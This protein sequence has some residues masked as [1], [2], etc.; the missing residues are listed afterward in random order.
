MDQDDG[1]ERYAYSRCMTR[2]CCLEACLCLAEGNQART[3][4]IFKAKAGTL[5][6]ATHGLALL[7]CKGITE[8]TTLRANRHLA[9]TQYFN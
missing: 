4:E 1:Q 9:G 5:E 7:L 2:G 3:G 6:L 8:I